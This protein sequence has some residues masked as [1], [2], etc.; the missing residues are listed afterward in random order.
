MTQ[1][2]LVDAGPLVA[3]LDRRDR[4]H[5]W[6]AREVASLQQPMITCEPI[7]TEAAYLVRRIPK[8][9]VSVI[10]LLRQQVVSVQFQLIK[11][12]DPIAAS[13]RRYR[14]VPMSLADACLVRMSELI[15]NC[16]VF[17]IDSDFH[18]YRRNRRQKIPLLIPPD[19]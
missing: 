14:D 5:R 4:Y 6:A 18:I 19:V 1:T 8:G 3:L 10:D 17:T 2:I 9:T 15:P 13:L 11:Q 12:Q 7:L 16:T